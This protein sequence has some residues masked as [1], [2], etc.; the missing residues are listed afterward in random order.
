MENYYNKKID[1]SSININ[2]EYDLLL[3]GPFANAGDAVNYADNVSPIAKSRIIP[4]LTKDKYSFSII[5][6]KN[7]DLLKTTKDVGAYMKF[8]HQIFPD[9]F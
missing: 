9:K 3:I 7:L 6:N 1:L 2:S 5:S 8:I 4:W